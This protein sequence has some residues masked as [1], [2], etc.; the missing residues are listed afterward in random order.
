MRNFLRQ[1]NLFAPIK[2]Q[3]QHPHAKTIQ[4]VSSRNLNVPKHHNITYI[5]VLSKYL[6]DK[7]LS[8]AGK[9]DWDG[10]LDEMRGGRNDF[11]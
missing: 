9:V 10:D 3:E 6:T 1:L 2:D 4:A 7:I 8:L 11:S 5:L